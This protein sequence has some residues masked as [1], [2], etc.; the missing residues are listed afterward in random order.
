MHADMANNFVNRLIPSPFVVF[1]W[2]TAVPGLP[3]SIR[4][5]MAQRS[6]ESTPVA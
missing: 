6:P 3:T 1:D 4:S 2:R 5:A